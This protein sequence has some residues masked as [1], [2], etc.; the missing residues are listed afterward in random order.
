MFSIIDNS[1]GVSSPTMFKRNGG[2]DGRDNLEYDVLAVVREVVSFKSNRESLLLKYWLR[3]L[4][5]R[6]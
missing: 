2:N 5:N 4:T 1:E 3:A 6:C